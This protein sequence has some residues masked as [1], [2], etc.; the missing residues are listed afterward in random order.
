MLMPCL[1]SNLARVRE[2][3]ASAAGRSGRDPL[4][5][6][7]IAVTKSVDAATAR[8]LSALGVSDFGESR[9]QAASP[10]VVA[11]SDLPIHWHFIGRLQSNKARKVLEQFEEIHSLDRLE[12][13]EAIEQSARDPSRKRVRVYLQVNVSGEVSK[14]GV[15]PREAPRLAERLLASS[16]AVDW[17]GLM[18]MAPESV[19]TE[20][21]RPVFAG[22]RVLG[23]RLC[24]EFGLDSLR[25]S[26]G[27]SDDFEVAVE[28]GATDIR[29][30]SALFEGL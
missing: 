24:A 7:L 3:I 5:V 21:A 6:R 13:L 22:L 15:A 19:D 11:L 4:S 1:A 25:L 12:L 8:G 23:E 14:A 29:V 30:G 27:M 28:E 16:A 18:A 20:G 17:V 10:K 9:Q 26:M 2:R